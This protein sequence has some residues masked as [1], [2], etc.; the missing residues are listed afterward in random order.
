MLKPCK[1][2]PSTEQD[3][4]CQILKGRDYCKDFKSKHAFAPDYSQKT[5]HFSCDAFMAFHS[6][7][8]TI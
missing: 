8:N 1:Q 7:Q 6:I 5:Q 3:R 4:E 2:G